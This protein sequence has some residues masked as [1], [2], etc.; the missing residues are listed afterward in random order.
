MSYRAVTELLDRT[1]LLASG[2]TFAV[3]G[4]DRE[5]TRTA[6]ALRAR[7]VVCEEDPQLAA[8]ARRE[9]FEVLPLREALAQAQ[10][11]LAPHVDASLLREGA[12]VGGGMVLPGDEVR[13]GVIEHV[14]ADGTSVFVVVS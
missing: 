10:L 3:V 11:V 7:V 4:W 5:V 1:N 13:E 14:R 12:V 2:K 8:E 9:G 6:R